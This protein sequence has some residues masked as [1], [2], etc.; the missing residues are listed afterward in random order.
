MPTQVYE[1]DLPYAFISYTHDDQATVD[2]ILE[3]MTNVGVRLWYDD[4]IPTATKWHEVI[5]GKI[6]NSSFFVAMLSKNYLKSKNCIPELSYAVTNIHLPVLA[7]Y[8]EPVELTEGLQ[9]YMSGSQAVNLQ[10]FNDDASFYEKLFDCELWQPCREEGASLDALQHAKGKR[11]LAKSRKQYAKWQYVSVFCLALL[12]LTIAFSSYMSQRHRQMEERH[13]AHQGETLYQR[14]MEFYC[15]LNGSRVDRAAGYKALLESSQLGNHRAQALLAYITMTDG[16][17]RRAPDAQRAY[18]LSQQ[19]AQWREPL[20]IV[21]QA[22]Y[23]DDPRKSYYNGNKA[24]ALYREALNAIVESQTKEDNTRTLL[25]LA[26]F[27]DPDQSPVDDF[28]VD[29]QLATRYLQ[30]ASNLGDAKAM[31]LYGAALMSQEDSQNSSQEGLRLIQTAVQVEEPEAFYYYGKCYESGMGVE[32]DVSKAR[33]LY[34]QGAKRGSINCVCMLSSF[35]ADGTGGKKDPKRAFELAHSAYSY[36]DPDVIALL[37]NYYDVGV[38]CKV[39]PQHAATLYRE[40][41]ELGSVGAM[42]ELAYAYEN[43]YGVEQDSVASFLWTSKAAEKGWPTAFYNLAVDYYTGLGVRQ[44]YQKAREYFQKALDADIEEAEVYL[45]KYNEEESPQDIYQQGITS[46]FGLDGHTIDLSDGFHKLQHASD[47]GSLAAKST[48]AWIYAHDETIAQE[49]SLERAEKLAS[50]SSLY[51]TSQEVLAMCAMAQDD[52]REQRRASVLLLDA[53]HGYEQDAQGGDVL[54]MFFLANLV[55]TEEPD[56]HD[57]ERASE[58]LVESARANLGVAKTVLALEIYSDQ[59]NSRY[60]LQKAVEILQNAAEQNER[61]A[62][63]NMGRAY[64]SGVGVTEDYQRAIDCFKKSAQARYLPA[65][66]QLAFCYLNGMGVEKDQTQGLAWYIRASV[67]GDKSVARAIA[68]RRGTKAYADA[69]YEVGKELLFGLSGQSVDRR[70]AILTLQE[71]SHRGNLA[72]QGLLATLL[73][74]GAG[75]QDA[76]VEEALEMARESARQGVTYAQILLARAE[77]LHYDVQLQEGELQRFIDEAFERL[78]DAV[79]Q[80][81]PLAC[82]QLAECYYLGIGVPRNLQCCAELYE[83]ASNQGLALAKYKLGL[84][85]YQEP[86]FKERQ[87]EALALFLEAADADLPEAICQLGACYYDGKCVPYDLERAVNYFRRAEQTGY[88]RATPY[89]A[90]RALATLLKTE[91]WSLEDISLANEYALKAKDNNDSVALLALGILKI[92]GFGEDFNPEEG[93]RALEKSADQGNLLATFY[94]GQCYEKGDGVTRNYKSAFELYAAAL[95]SYTPEQSVPPLEFY[96]SSQE[97]IENMGISAIIYA[98]GRCYQLGRGVEKNLDTAREY[99]QR[100]LDDYPNSWVEEKAREGL[101][102]PR[103]NY[104]DR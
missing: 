34:E 82:A 10:E 6:K 94:L 49:A 12:A 78:Q 5:A 29:S 92:E 77:Q 57:Q 71:G 53:L 70:A 48:L 73:F 1:G 59:E 16:E 47:L 84:L 41:A 17:P 3:T 69:L 39:D 2:L 64:L 89:V 40:A 79:K 98:L 102:P 21:T 91:E 96:T 24:Q 4:G 32:E 54:A 86:E 93:F 85:L 67:A 43:G 37:A 95:D 31:C 80:K 15:G 9:M 38:G 104:F 81:D 55:S 74:D 99:Y 18:E 30:R 45:H 76:K 42:N 46:Y 11:N 58:L 72:A 52:W 88:T 44:D 20:A 68:Q 56:L 25:V 19:P 75:F 7:I 14:G 66:S 101:K 51:P 100:V 26:N 13:I 27:L 87:K 103:V 23:F 61:F 28:D 50:E 8:L 65:M 62:L 60:D 97:L 83:E 33:E 22:I 36:N 90:L 63:Y 35:Y